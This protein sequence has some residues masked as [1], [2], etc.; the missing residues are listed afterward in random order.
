MLGS[1]TRIYTPEGLIQISKLKVNDYVIA[2]DGHKIQDTKI[3]RIMK[4]NYMLRDLYKFH[5]EH[6][7]KKVTVS[8]DHNF[9][10]ADET[11]EIAD[12][13]KFKNKVLGIDRK[14]TK[15]IGKEAVINES[16]IKKMERTEHGYVVMYELKLY[17]NKNM[18]FF[19][20]EKIV[21]YS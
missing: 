16:Q 11:H 7:D 15:I 19:S 9:W 5:F 3:Q 4:H 17:D 20:S 13:I 18:Y 8:I 2:W 14:K 21:T 10:L 6:A 12:K 1:R